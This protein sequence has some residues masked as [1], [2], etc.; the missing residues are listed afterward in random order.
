M[1]EHSVVELERVP[2][3][4]DLYLRALVRMFPLLRSGAGQIPTTTVRLPE[5]RID[6][7][8]LAAYTEVCGLPSNGAVPLTYPFVSANPLT[9]QLMVSRTFPFALPGL[10]HLNNVIEQQRPLEV[11][12]TLSVA[13]YLENLRDHRRGKVFDAVTAVSVGAEPVWKQT[14]TFLKQQ[15]KPPGRKTTEQSAQ[16]PAQPQE[17]IRVTQRTIDDYA[18]TSGDRNPIHVSTIGARLL[19]FPST[20]AHGMWEAAAVL[21]ALGNDVPEAA[22]YE[23]AFGRPLL[24]PGT[25][26]LFADRPGDGGDWRLSLRSPKNDAV[27][28]TATLTA[29]PS[30]SE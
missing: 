25:V 2:R 8:N 12:E 26:H 20:I 7:D 15:G 21:R 29:N 27:H 22:R 11:S 5:L 3:I 24:L 23:V 13:V 10:V 19:G 9:M 4:R 17:T 18:A 1:T 16:T 28:L 30:Q 14:A 6:R